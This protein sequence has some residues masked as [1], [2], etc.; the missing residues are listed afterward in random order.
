MVVKP[1]KISAPIDKMETIRG[2]FL[3]RIKLSSGTIGEAIRMQEWEIQ[4]G[5]LQTKS[6][7]MGHDINLMNAWYQIAVH[8]KHNRN[9]YALLY[10]LK[11]LQAYSDERSA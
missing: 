2:L 1:L 7:K 11:V 3:V 10:K 6:T 4:N 5:G 8:H 9:T